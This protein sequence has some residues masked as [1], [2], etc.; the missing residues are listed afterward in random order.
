L[1]FRFIQLANKLLIGLGDSFTSEGG[2]NSYPIVAA[3]LLNWQVRNFAIGGSKLSGIPIQL[4][5]ASSVL[6]N[7]THVVFTTGGND[8]DIGAAIMQVVLTNN[9]AAVEAK[10]L[11][12]KHSLV[13]TY[14]LIKGSVRPG[15]KVFASPYVNFISVGNK[16][17]NE[18]E[19][20]RLMDLASVTIKA[21]ADEVN[22]GYIK[23]VEK[24]FVGH[25]M[26]SDDPYC[27]GIIGPDAAHP[28]AKGYYKLG[29]V[30][31]EFLKSQ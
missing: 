17:P 14:K 2:S 26:F 29:E 7:A 5:T 22:I 6:P 20:H 15:T 3:R 27:G 19:C 31:A 24:A 16:I 4:G 30:V 18:A 10:I 9:S 21:A 25:E 8:V 13:S 11:A 1:Y 28:N 23:E 12:L